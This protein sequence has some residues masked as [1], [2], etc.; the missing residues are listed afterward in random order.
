MFLTFYAILLCLLLLRTASTYLPHTA[1]YCMHSRL[2][3]PS[4]FP[5]SSRLNV[6]VY[7]RINTECPIILGKLSKKSCNI[8]YCK[9]IGAV[10]KNNMSENVFR[11]GTQLCVFI[12]KNSKFVLLY[13]V[14][15]F[16][17]AFGYKTFNVKFY[18][19]EYLSYHIIF[20]KS[21]QK[22]TA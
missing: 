17:L 21:Y 1:E 11:F 14:F 5:P 6:C 3:L 13:F 20:E 9:I 12:R 22:T 18:M 16:S 7:T 19:P 10:L 8:Q 15:Q 2:Y 4:S